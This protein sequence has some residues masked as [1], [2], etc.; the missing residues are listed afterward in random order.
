MFDL[1]DPSTFSDLV[2]DEVVWWEIGSDEPIRSK[3]AVFALMSDT[4]GGL[5]GLELHDVVANDD[6][7]AALI[8]ATVR[9]G[10]EEFSY[11][12]ARKGLLTSAPLSSRGGR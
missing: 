12:T 9:R 5:V 2:A 10:D 8:Q 11:L 3:E 6:H 7:L 1:G 4:N